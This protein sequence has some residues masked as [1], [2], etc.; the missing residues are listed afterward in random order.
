MIL[1]I[2]QARLGSERFPRKVLADLCG[3]PMI[4]HVY[5]R[6]RRIRGLDNV[7]ITIPADDA[8]AFL[9]MG[10]STPWWPPGRAWWA[11]HVAVNDV[12]AR[13][14]WVAQAEGADTVMRLTADCPLLD[15]RICERVLALYQSDLDCEYASNIAPGYIDG[16]DCE[17][18]S[19]SALHLAQR[20][21]T[22]PFDREH[23]SPWIRRHVKCLTL[24][25]DSPEPKQKTSVDTP[26]DLEYVRSL[27]CSTAV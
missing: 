11:V 12:L 23:V 25:A 24:S 9:A 14:D 27:L 3:R 4:H 26:A 13:F 20:E 1:A 18:F 8:G 22:D 6:A 17:V 7:L 21:A 15:P 5:E 16:T 2:I 10:W 19:A